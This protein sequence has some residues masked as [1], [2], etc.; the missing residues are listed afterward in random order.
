M[1]KEGALGPQLGKGPYAQ[2]LSLLTGNEGCNACWPVCPIAASTCNGC[3]LCGL[4]LLPAQEACLTLSLCCILQ[5]PPPSQQLWQ[6]QCYLQNSKARKD[7]QGHVHGHG[8]P[9]AWTAEP[10]AGALHF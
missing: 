5:R 10:L 6:N 9:R 2:G 4:V 8:W 7:E 3:W 1:G